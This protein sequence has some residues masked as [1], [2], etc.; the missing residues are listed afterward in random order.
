MRHAFVFIEVFGCEG[1]IQSYIQDVLDAYA[2]IAEA[3][4]RSMI[5]D[6]FLLRD[7]Q[8]P[9]TLQKDCFHYHYFGEPAAKNDRSMTGRIRLTLALAT[10]LAKHRPERVYCG[11][12]NL[13]AMVSRICRTLKIPYTI[14]T[15]GKEVWEELPPKEQKALSAASRIWTISR[16]SRD[17]ACRANNLSSDQFDM[18]PCVVDGS[19]FQP[20]LPPVQLAER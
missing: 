17:L 7:T 6:V 2:Q 20:G 13:A 12:I 14:L 9:Q 18:L 8:T 16:Y 10:Y 15:Y 11:H 19:V 4:D 1:G 3:Q 5:A